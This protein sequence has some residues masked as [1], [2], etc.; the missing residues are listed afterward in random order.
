MSISLLSLQQFWGY[1]ISLTHNLTQNRKNS[2]ET[3]EQRGQESISFRVEEFPN[4]PET[5]KLGS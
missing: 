5:I 2:V 4:V 1:P 3:T